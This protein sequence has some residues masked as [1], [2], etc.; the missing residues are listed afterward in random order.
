MHAII[1]TYVLCTFHVSLAFFG[2]WSIPSTSISSWVLGHSLLWISLS[3]H[4]FLLSE[5]RENFGGLPSFKAREEA[6]V[7][8]PSRPSSP[9]NLRASSYFPLVLL[10]C[11]SK[12]IPKYC[13]DIIHPKKCVFCWS[14]RPSCSGFPQ[15]FRSTSRTRYRR[16][17]VTCCIWCKVPIRNSFHFRE[18]AN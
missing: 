17:I 13:A 10:S 11:G 9:C 6:S 5:V 3:F 12:G 2:N 16:T 1:C 8:R 4:V 14:K 15:K 7:W 18:I